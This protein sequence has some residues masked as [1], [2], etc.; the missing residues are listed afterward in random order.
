MKKNKKK[1]LFISKFAISCF[2]L[3]LIMLGTVFIEAKSLDSN[4]INDSENSLQ[5]QYNKDI[6]ISKNENFFENDMYS[7]E[8]YIEEIEEDS[9]IASYSVE[10]EGVAAVAE[11]S[12]IIPNSFIKD[13]AGF[14]TK[15]SITKLS[16]IYSRNL[17]SDYVKVGDLHSVSIY[18]NK[19]NLGD[20]AVTLDNNGQIYA[21]ENCGGFF[22]TW[23]GTSASPPEAYLENITNI[24]FENFNTSNTTNMCN[25]FVGC[26]NIESLD[27]HTFNTSKIENFGSFFAGCNK[28]NDVNLTGFDFSNASEFASFFNS[29]AFKKIDLSS[30]NFSGKCRNISNFFSSCK[31]LTEVIFPKQMNTNLIHFGGVFRDCEKLKKI[32]FGGLDCS[33]VINF[34]ETFKGCK[35]LETIDLSRLNTSS[36]TNMN[37]MFHSCE[38][39]K[40]VDLSSFNTSNVTD[41]GRMFYN[42]KNLTSLDLSNFDTKKVTNMVYMFSHCNELKSLN[43]TSFNTSNVTNMDSLFYYCQNLTSL[44]LSSFNTGNVNSMTYLF[45]A[46]SKLKSIIIDP[47]LFKTTKVTNMAGLFYQCH[48][49]E[50]LDVSGFDTSNVTNMNHMFSGCHK[51]TSIDVSGFDTSNVVDMC[52]MFSNCLLLESIDVSNFVTKNVFNIQYMFYNCKKLKEIDVTNFNTL[53]LEYASETFAFCDALE[54][55]NLSSFDLSNMEK[56]SYTLSGSETTY[57]NC[58]MIYQCNSLNELITPK[59]FNSNI[60][61]QTFDMYFVECN[62]FNE[63]FN[64]FD[65][66][67]TCM[68]FLRVFDVNYIKDDTM[69]FTTTQVDEYIYTQGLNIDNIILTKENYNFKG[70]YLDDKFNTKATNLTSTS[71]GDITLYPKFLYDVT[72]AID[73]NSKSTFEY[74]ANDIVYS[75]IDKN[76]S[77][78]LNDILNLEYY[79]NNIW[80]TNLPT[81][82]GKYSIKL[83]KLADDVYDSVTNLTITEGLV[84]ERKN[85]N[86]CDI[87]EI[88]DQV[89]K[90]VAVKPTIYIINNNNL[91]EL[92]LSISGEG[93]FTASYEDNLNKGEA[94]VK[95][96]GI[97]NYTGNIELIFNIVGQSLSNTEE[98]TMYYEL[99]YYIEANAGTLLGELDLNNNLDSYPALWEFVY[100]ED[101]SYATVLKLG[102]FVIDVVCKPRGEYKNIYDELKSKILVIVRSNAP[103]ITNI[104]INDSNT[105]TKTY[106]TKPI[107]NIKFNYNNEDKNIDLSN[108]PENITI[109]FKLNGISVL[110]PVNAGIYSMK[111]KVASDDI[112]DE[113]ITETYLTINKKQINSQMISNIEDQSYTGTQIIPIINISYTIEDETIT[114]VQGVDYTTFGGANIS[115]EG[116]VYVIGQGNYTT[117][118]ESSGYVYK[119][120]NI[121][122]GGNTIYHVDGENK[123]E[124]VISY[125]Y[126]SN[127]IYN[128]TSQ[129]PTFEIK[130][131][132]SSSTPITLLNG[133][134][135]DI[136]VVSSNTTNVQIGIAVK[137]TFKG[138]Y[139]GYEFK[140]Y[141]INA[142]TLSESNVNNDGIVTVN[143]NIL[144]ENIDY[145]RELVNDISNHSEGILS[146][147]YLYTGINNYNGS[148]YVT[149]STDIETFTYFK[150]K[151]SNIKFSL[152]E[153]NL[154]LKETEHNIGNKGQSDLYLDYTGQSLKIKAFIDLLE[155]S[156]ST[157][158]S[159]KVYKSSG[160]LISSSLHNFNTITTNTK[161]ELL[162]EEGNVLDSFII[163]IRGDANGDGKINSSD[164]SYIKNASKGKYT[165][166]VYAYA[167]DMNKDGRINSNDFKTLI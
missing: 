165:S 125:A 158:T 35:S 38:S 107:N 56:D 80:T 138:S 115:N 166:I 31:N 12:V 48:S 26:N 161:F 136:F 134:D 60:I 71:F 143:D 23:G 82:V 85:I 96:V 32:D 92:V 160:S 111:I 151:D 63:Q 132:T 45:Y 154:I 7:D 130:D 113:I 127:L 49:L 147:K 39:L 24:Y 27:L 118:Q 103:S 155:N 114:L 2:I 128:G 20:V 74:S 46:C 123:T 102:S 157:K 19:T 64:V 120:F 11:N 117:E 135:Y 14:Y 84:I 126:N 99:P 54:S 29:T 52:S 86:T 44:N 142:Y 137:I 152:V 13:L 159:I 140:S 110:K 98:L 139:E 57:Y 25:M 59:R 79:V 6:N 83:N 167:A 91:E 144:K 70:W 53:S 87:K 88:E 148:F 50:N 150:F 119:T 65:E 22:G 78:R 76:N 75:V 89:Y 47:S 149:L 108:I 17:I 37:S 116:Y 43:L 5:E 145:T 95:I 41:M 124:A 141:N 33:K 156:T 73:E 112:Y 94:K 131:T 106:D 8:E 30:W 15:A 129:I 100:T 122:G 62:D 133:V 69:T 105:L 10:N 162:D 28:L 101:Y 67:L 34:I 90:G 146:T 72:S 97:N 61:L 42:C 21:T 58:K 55:L 163:V 16:F 3:C 1:I 51:L 153:K 121:I 104:S 40:S 81:E 68:R 93:D 9:E 164:I 109:E 66:Y 36:A 77:N 4:T 18:Y